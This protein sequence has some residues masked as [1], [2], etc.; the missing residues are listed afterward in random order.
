MR[1][2]ILFTIFASGIVIK[3]SN[4]KTYKIIILLLSILVITFPLYKNY[5]NIVLSIFDSNASSK[6]G[7]SNAQMRF[8]QLSASIEL[9]KLSPIGGLGERFMVLIKN[10]YIDKIL[11]ME[12]FIF[13]E[14][15][16]HGLVGLIST[17]YL[18]IISVFKIPYKFKV[19]EIFWIS[20][21]LW[22]IYT[23]TS[24][25]FFRMNLYYIV[26]FYF[27]KNSQL[28]IESKIVKRE[29]DL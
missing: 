12:S 24:I 17:I 13:E 7:G 20:F 23:L 27:I 16:K 18:V 10:Q 3:M 29:E 15:C 25:P 21:A 2:G 4:K 28:Y 8:E 9:M 14:L 6:V 22:G 26:V 11:A 19:R 5:L 1:A